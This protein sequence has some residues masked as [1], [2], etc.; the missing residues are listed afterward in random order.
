MRENLRI[1]VHHPLSHLAKLPVADLGQVTLVVIKVLLHSGKPLI[2]F[3]S[4][5]SEVVCLIRFFNTIVDAH[6]S[7]RIIN[8]TG[9]MTEITIDI[10]WLESLGSLGDF[11]CR[12][13]SYIIYSACLFRILTKLFHRVLR[14]RNRLRQ[15]QL[16][17]A[18]R[19]R[20]LFGT[21]VIVYIDVAIV[22]LDVF[23]F[24]RQFLLNIVACGNSASVEIIYPYS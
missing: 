20:S 3:L 5:R 6:I 11:L 10:E 1:I 13:V 24:K 15:S 9:S 22:V 21:G 19:C 18:R 8:M 16:I 2:H 14:S 23:Y 12:K 17:Y 4:E 7:D